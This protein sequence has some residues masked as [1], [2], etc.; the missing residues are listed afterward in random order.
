MSYTDSI[1]ALARDVLQRVDWERE[2]NCPGYARPANFGDAPVITTPPM[3]P[4][5]SPIPARTGGI[6][7][8]PQPKTRHAVPGGR[9][10]E[11]PRGFAPSGIAPSSPQQTSYD[12]RPSSAASLNSAASNSSN[13]PVEQSRAHAMAALKFKLETCTLCPLSEGRSRIV[14]SDG[15]MSGAIAFIGDAP[16]REEDVVSLPF[17]GQRGHLLNKIILAIGQ[18][19]ETSYLCNVV[20]CAPP[21]GRVATRTEL[22]TCGDFL[23]EQLKLVSP[24]VIVALGQAPTELLLNTQAELHTL[25]GKFHQWNNIPVMPTWSLNQMLSTP[26]VKREVWDDLKQVKAMLESTSQQTES[27]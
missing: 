25:R 5:P 17:I 15:T 4:A 14:F 9:P 13:P 6:P 12:S 21:E 8:Q 10:P 3:T 19:R 7:A 18:R 1:L 27:F 11:E 26:A 23:F 24:K 2:L 22:H 16:S 20:K